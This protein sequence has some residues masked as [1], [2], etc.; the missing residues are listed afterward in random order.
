MIWAIGI[1][2]SFNVLWQI[3]GQFYKG[4]RRFLIPSLAT[5]YAYF[6][7]NYKERKNRWACSIILFLVAILSAGYGVDSDLK[8]WCGGSETLTRV[9][10]ASLIS[11]VFIAYNLIVGG[12]LWSIPAI[13][14]L[15]I[16]AWQVR[17]GTI[18]KV[19]K[20]DILGDDI[21]RSTACAVSLIIA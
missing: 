2:V 9:A 14:A 15:N 8:R 6:F 18:C 13:L 12:H 1:V 17:W 11:L 10:V 19:G 20:Y 21:C 5:A 4:A 7:K 3:G 16:G